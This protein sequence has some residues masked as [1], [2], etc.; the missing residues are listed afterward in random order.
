MYVDRDLQNMP[1]TQGLILDYNNE[2]LGDSDEDDNSQP[3]MFTISLSSMIP[4]IT[5]AQPDQSYWQ[6]TSFSDYQLNALEGVHLS[7][8]GMLLRDF[9]DIQ[10]TS[11]DSIM[12]SINNNTDNVLYYT[13]PPGPPSTILEKNINGEWYEVPIL[14]GAE[15]S[16]RRHPP[17]I[18][19]VGSKESMHYLTTR[20]SF[21]RPNAEG[22]YRLVVEVFFDP[23]SEQRYF[24]SESFEI[25]KQD[26]RTRFSKEQVNSLDGLSIT[27]IKYDYEADSL[28]YVVRNESG[29]NFTYD[30]FRELEKYIEG[31]WYEVP[32]N[33]YSPTGQLQGVHLVSRSLFRRQE[34]ESS[35]KLG[36][37]HPLSVGT[38]R[39]TM[40]PYVDGASPSER[41]YFPI[42]AV[43]RIVE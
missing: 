28:L 9:P 29:L 36:I 6:R 38:Y 21:W 31:T 24:L 35:I 34:F 10:R 30:D 4:S 1:D 8:V 11:G 17:V 23:D 25:R 27:L 5:T 18:L 7:N 3:E 42:S 20:L 22:L 43:F 40:I 39:I 19:S 26:F 33:L 32:A 15:I 2:M 16:L 14:R 12:F 13:F 37:W 41:E